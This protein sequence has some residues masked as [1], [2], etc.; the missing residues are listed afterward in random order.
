MTLWIHRYVVKV[1][2]QEIKKIQGTPYEYSAIE[3]NKYVLSEMDKEELNKLLLDAQSIE[4]R[5][6]MEIGE[7]K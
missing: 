6:I 1:C 4:S 7:R 2:K 3:L 5:I